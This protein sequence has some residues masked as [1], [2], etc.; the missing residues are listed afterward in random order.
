MLLARLEGEDEAALAVDVLGLP[1]DATGHAPD[2]G[3]GGGEEPERRTA[4][5]QAVPE[6]LPL[7]DHD[8]HA[9]L[10]RRLEDGERKRV[11]GRDEERAGVVRRLRDRR[12]ILHR[13]EEVRLLDD[14]RADV[15]GEVRRARWR[16]G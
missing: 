7:A 1:G 6:R 2:E 9:A 4:E 3:L 10:A 15:V 13:A 8:V 14:D 11:A 12:Q 16:P 5:V